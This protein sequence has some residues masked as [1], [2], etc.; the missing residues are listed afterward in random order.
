MQAQTGHGAAKT[1]KEPGTESGFKDAIPPG[2]MLSWGGRVGWNSER[3]SPKRLLEPGLTG[4]RI[5]NR[6][7]IYTE[8]RLFN[9]I[10]LTSLHVPTTHAHKETTSGPEN[11]GC[12]CVEVT[13]VDLQPLPPGPAALCVTLGKVTLSTLPN[14]QL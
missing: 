5:L 9:L 13:G 4:S 11:K 2:T 10:E 1:S 6:L 7:N 3:E 8:I 12:V 14:P